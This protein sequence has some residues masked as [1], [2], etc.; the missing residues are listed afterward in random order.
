MHSPHLDINLM[1]EKLGSHICSHSQPFTL[2]FNDGI[3][4]ISGVPW[5]AQTNIL[6]HAVFTTSATVYQKRNN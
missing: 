2:F 3:S 4:D 1:Q 5:A 6:L